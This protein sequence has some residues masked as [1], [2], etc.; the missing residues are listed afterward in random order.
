MVAGGAR[1]QKETIGFEELSSL[2]EAGTKY[3]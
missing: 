1:A 2:N 3:P